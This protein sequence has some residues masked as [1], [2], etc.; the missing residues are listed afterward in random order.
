MN[1]EL[2]I[3]TTHE[4]MINRGW[5]SV[6]IVMIS[7]DAYVDHPSF[8][9]PLLARLLESEGYRV[10]LIAQPDINNKEDFLRF[11]NPRLCVM[12]GSGNIDSMVSHYTSANKKRSNDFYTPGGKSGKRPDRATIV[13]TNRAKAAFNKNIPIIIGGIEASLRKFAHFDIWSE[14]VRHS[15]LLDSKADILIYGMGELTTLELIRRL[16]NGETKE[17]L[18]DVRG[19]VVSFSN[20]RFEEIK[21]TFKHPIF[22]IPS[23]EEVSERDKKSNQPTENGKLNY[24][25]AF[26]IGMLHE[27]P[28]REECLFQ[29]SENRIVFRNPIQRPLTTKEMDRVY[30]LPFTRVS[31]VDYDKFGGIPAL[32][33]VQF[34]ITSNRGCYG[35]CSFCAITSHQGRM[36]QVR[37]K[38]SLVREA[39]LLTKLPNFKGYIH[40]L[41]GPTANFQ[42]TA[43]D[44]QLKYGPCDTKQCLFP[45]PCNNLKDSHERYLD[46]LEA[47]ENIKGVKKVFIRSGIR[48][49]YLMR[50]AKPKTRDKFLKHLVLH[51]V[52]GQL[53]IAPEHVDPSVLDIM[54]KPTVDI[55]EE[56][57]VSFK[58]TNE[59]LNMK[60]YTI[61]Y[62]I[63]AH[64]GSTLQSAINLALHTKKSGFVPD[65][66]QEFYPT[67]STVSTCMYYTGLDPRPNRDFQEVY[68]PKG[69]E[70]KLQRAILQFDKVENRALVIEALKKAHRMDLINVLL[71]SNNNHNLHKNRKNMQKNGYN[72]YKKR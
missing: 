12:I 27:N 64:P 20:K 41:G 36:I 50:V 1:R 22:E 51:N 47:I 21:D 37:S 38:E 24:A 46:I 15:V 48:F 7:G 63:A 13:Y 59:K 18:Y 26:Q 29:R 28:I 35:A 68:V 57:I 53:K 11:G 62:F 33:E 14:K 3:P 55:Y 61:P 17:T 66:G 23:F 71:P 65:Q 52:S 67:P 69:R 58:E 16:N 70:K 44:K 39:T 42:A 10:G 60:Q 8:G 31:H 32:K 40:D 6:D 34:S 19:T 54:G 56:F 30:E 43:C 5:D 2:F 72:R 4:D 49:D 9:V 45:T 25:K